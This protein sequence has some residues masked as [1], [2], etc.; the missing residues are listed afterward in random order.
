MV[1]RVQG[2]ERVEVR[3]VQKAEI[4]H[5]LRAL[6]VLKDRHV[7]HHPAVRHEAPP[8]NREAVHGRRGEEGN[9]S[10]GSEGADQVL[11]REE[12]GDRGPLEHKKGAPLMCACV[13]ACVCVGG[14][15]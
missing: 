2:T 6:I 11:A 7:V 1:R 5:E 4:D 3:V 10:G 12:R 14:C 15:G 8:P 13:R 9:R